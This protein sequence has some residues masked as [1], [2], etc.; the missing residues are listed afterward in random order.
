M[1]ACQQSTSVKL[2]R[3]KIRLSANINVS[4]PVD[5]DDDMIESWLN[6]SSAC[7][8]NHVDR[9]AAVYARMQR[10]GLCSCPFV[11]AE[12]APKRKNP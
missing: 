3:V 5:W 9:L 1:L 12:V 4:V 7:M 8:D 2:K 11:K 10:A 6:E